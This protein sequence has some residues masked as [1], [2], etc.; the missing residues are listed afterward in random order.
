MSQQ[1][2]NFALEGQIHHSKFYVRSKMTC[3]EAKPFQSEG[4]QDK[5]LIL[6]LNADDKITTLLLGFQVGPRS[7]SW[8]QQSSL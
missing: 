4:K 6:C 2:L 1:E 8:D 3:I 5:S 7:L